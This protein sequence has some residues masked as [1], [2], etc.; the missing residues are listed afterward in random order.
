[1]DTTRQNAL[2][3]LLLVADGALVSIAA[4][5]SFFV[6]LA[7]R[8][9]LPFLKQPPALDQYF[10]V[11]VLAVPTWVALSAVFDLHRVLER[12]W[13]RGELALGLVKLHV[14][15][16]LALAA[17]LFLSQGVLNRS[18]VGL[19]VVCSFT[20]TYAE[21]A[22]LGRWVRYQFEHGHGRERL[23]LVGA[24]SPEL[25]RFVDRCASDPLPPTLVGLVGAPRDAGAALPGG[26]RALGD[27][28]ALPEVL[29]DEPV[30]RVLFFP[31]HDDPRRV[32]AALEACETLGVP[33]EF[34]LDLSP[35]GGMVPTLRSLHG[36]TF[37]HFEPAPKP[38]LLLA[39]K[40]AFDF[41]ASAAGLVV[42]SP[43]LLATALAILVTMGRPVLFLQ[44]R[45]GLRGRSFRMLKFRTMVADAERRRAEL[46]PENEM[47][48]PVFKVTND[49]RVTR[50]GALLR[51]T[52]ID[53]LP[54]L[55]NVLLGTMSLVGPRPLPVDEQRAIRGWHRRR[56][57]MKPGIT[58][59]WQIGGRSDV[60]FEA[61]MRLDLAYVDA[62]SLWL[63]LRILLATIPVV[64]SRRGAR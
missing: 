44:E 15:G 2:R 1:L 59:T 13:T 14:S 60:D 45:A 24:A 52:S 11:A 35:S 38:P 49:P 61:W 42:L 58:C 63:D 5:T 19:F 41:A 21:R 3:K 16:T 33:A 17:V 57:S 28:G 54:Q 23:L 36:E 37:V 32:T 53:E 31:P 43:L 48:G 62:W 51:K 29:H 47:S 12:P 10:L 22:A 6:H 50:L 55:F 4:A 9:V 30:D 26:L 34:A 46:L 56:L 39:L 27:V 7:L 18:L 64:L 8:A 40:H 20:L 25:A